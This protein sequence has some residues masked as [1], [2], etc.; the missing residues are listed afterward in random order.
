MSFHFC[1]SQVQPNGGWQRGYGQPAAPVDTPDDAFLDAHTTSV[2]VGPIGR[3]L[4]YFRPQM[5][6]VSNAAMADGAAVMKRVGGGFAAAESA[7]ASIAAAPMPAPAA[8]RGTAAMAT[9]AGALATAG[10]A[11]ADGASV[12]LQSQF[13]VTPLFSV[14]RARADGRGQLN[15]TA[16]QSLGSYVI[17]A[18][19]ATG[20]AWYGAAEAQIRVRRSVSLTPSLPRFARVGDAFEGGVLVSVPPGQSQTVVTVSC[21]AAAAGGSAG[22]DAPVVLLAEVR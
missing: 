1:S 18:Y 12:R 5:L 19:A 7:S 2:T 4:S 6:A 8:A 13:L 16:P 14:L 17:R 9:D 3:L 11:A 22:G 21:E 15:F 20:D 10:G